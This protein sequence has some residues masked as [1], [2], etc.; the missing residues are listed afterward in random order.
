MLLELRAKDQE[1]MTADLLL[2]TRVTIAYKHKP[3]LTDLRSGPAR[4]R[5]PGIGRTQWLWQEF[6]G[7]GHPRPAPN[8]RRHGFGI[9][10][11][12]TNGSC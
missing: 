10:P 1:L 11:G 6:I 2:S 5:D 12:G 7:F 8:E 9:D 3:V 4:R